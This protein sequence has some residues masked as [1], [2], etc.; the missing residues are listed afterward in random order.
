M[1][2]IDQLLCEYGAET[3]TTLS[4]LSAIDQLLIQDELEKQRKKE[5]R[6]RLK[7]QNKLIVAEEKAKEI[8]AARVSENPTF[9]EIEKYMI[10]AE[11]SGNKDSVK[12]NDDETIDVSK[13]G[14]NERWINQFPT[15]GREKPENNGIEP[16]RK[17]KDGTLDPVYAMI[18]DHMREQIPNWDNVNDSSRLEIIKDEVYSQPIAR[19]I[20][21][22]RG[23]RQ[24]SSYDRFME[25]YQTDLR[26]QA[27]DNM[28]A[29]V[30]QGNIP[31][32]DE[33]AQKINLD[34]ATTP[35]STAIAIDPRSPVEKWDD[36][37]AEAKKPKNFADAINKYTHDPVRLVPFLNTSSD[38]KEIVDITNIMQ[39]V[40]KATEEDVEP[41]REDMLRLYEYQQANQSEKSFGYKVWTVLG[42]L[43]SFALEIGL[44][45]GVYS[46]GKKA[47]LT[48]GK[49]MLKK[50]LSK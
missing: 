19:F 32:L 13:H 20:H 4:N 38:I 25:A 31:P 29:G 45:G 28:T 40:N 33:I 24:W 12:V 34:A 27:I 21:D 26:S 18:H 9:D 49:F 43:P 14:I 1:S 7:E 42:E 48:T 41:S 16:W 3:D 6:L 35:E 8:E 46:A 5:E 39:R 47:T 11:S 36:R 17:Q 37:I 15:S 50:A 30:F 22:Y 44:T 10:F 23:P 2:Y